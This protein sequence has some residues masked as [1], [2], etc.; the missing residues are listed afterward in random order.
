MEHSQPNP[1][2]IVIRVS[3]RGRSAESTLNTFLNNHGLVAATRL[4]SHYDYEGF[5]E[6]LERNIGLPPT[7]PLVFNGTQKVCSK[8]DLEL[9]IISIQIGATTLPSLEGS[10]LPGLILHSGPSAGTGLSSDKTSSDLDDIYDA[11]PRRTPQ[12]STVKDIAVLETI[13]T[14]NRPESGSSS[15]VIIAKLAG[16]AVP[17][18]GAA[19]KSLTY[20]PAASTPSNNADSPAKKRKPSDGHSQSYPSSKR[21]RPEVIELSDD[22]DEPTQRGASMADEGISEHNMSGTLAGLDDDS[23]DVHWRQ[24]EDIGGHFANRS[25]STKDWKSLCRMFQCREDVEEH[26]PVGFKMALSDYQLHGIWWMITQ[27]PIRG[28]PGGCLGDEMGLGKT[29]EVLSVFVLFALIKTSYAEVEKYWREGKTI[30]GRRHLPEDQENMPDA[31]CPSQHLLPSGL[32]CPCVKSGDTYSIATKLPSLP[33]ICFAPPTAIHGWRREFEIFIDVDHP[34]MKELKLSILHNDFK[35]D[36]TYYHSDS[37]IQETMAKATRCSLNQ[38]WQPHCYLKGRD[39]LSNWLLLV[40]SSG[41]QGLLAAYNGKRVIYRSGQ[42]DD[43]HKDTVFT[44]NGLAASFVFF[45]E[46]H[47]YRGSLSS[48]TQPYSI[49]K[50]ITRKSWDLTV[51]FSVSGSISAGG[52][53]QLV[54]TVD[55]IL[56]VKDEHENGEPKIGGITR[57]AQLE[58]KK[59]DWKYL[60]RNYHMVGNPKIKTEVEKR[61]ESMAELMKELVPH[62]LMARRNV[63]EFRGRTIG[64][65]GRKIVIGHIK[66]NM[67]DGPGRDAFCKLTA[68]VQTYVSRA[69]DERHNAWILGG[70][71]GTEPTQRSVELEFFGG[72]SDGVTAMKLGKV[73]SRSWTQLLRANVFPEVAHLYLDHLITEKDLEHDSVN[74]YGDEACLL[75]ATDAGR[76]GLLEKLA[77]SPFWPYRDQLVNQSSKFAKLCEYVEDMVAYRDRQFDIHDPGPA[78]G[79]NI[80]HMTIFS[81]SA[82][83]SFIAFMLLCDKF[84]QVQVMIINGRTR[85]VATQS[86]PGYGRREMVENLMSDCTRESRNKI[87]ISTYRICGTALNMQRANYCI[88]LEP[89]RDAKEEAQAA[90]R[91]NR[92]GQCMKPVIVRLHDERNLPETL[93]RA[94]HQNQGEMETWQEQGIRWSG[95]VH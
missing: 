5:R 13:E 94:R 14:D 64:D 1:D 6:Y 67:I 39:G 71:K 4:S 28:V 42:Q 91:I 11:T 36:E 7:E 37:R 56:R 9:L 65:D 76:E 85:G 58:E 68:H 53:C 45:D 61:K 57:V 38:R 19:E 86:V 22:D 75:A 48:P 30:D 83:S 15:D 77:E 54:N 43:K 55:H 21:P 40:S 60:L 12:R 73:G 51:A 34:I 16:T 84:P 72:Q 44:T 50:M 66:C 81:D 52:P 18:T 63:D 93:K 25:I 80:R 47:N 3:H 10:S 90:A 92:R 87:I 8:H 62:V 82:V 32:L 88:L 49:L 24:V 89:A 41:A 78:D 59:S 74:R 95:F 26:K 31:I 69:F 23:D 33:T 17:S 35:G 27:Y 70:K 29:V 20:M 2:H 79:S 46:A